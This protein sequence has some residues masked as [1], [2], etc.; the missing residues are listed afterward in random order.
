MGLVAPTFSGPVNT[1]EGGAS[2]SRSAACPGMLAGSTGRTSRGGTARSS[3]SGPTA[4]RVPG[5]G[6]PSS[7]IRAANSSS[8]CA[9]V[10]T[11]GT[12]T[13]RNSNSGKPSRFIP[14]VFNQA[15]EPGSRCEAET[16]QSDSTAGSSSSSA[17]RGSTISS[18]MIHRES[19]TS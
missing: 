8:K 3:S 7:A 5:G 15:G 11:K 14:E 2:G 13:S 12:G 18:R 6:G 1:I 10:G 4:M 9:V 16:H 19:S 17:N